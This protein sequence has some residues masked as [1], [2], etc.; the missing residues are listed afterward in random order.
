MDTK[1][2][3]AIVDDEENLRFLIRENLN[4]SGVCVAFS[5]ADVMAV[6]KTCQSE[7]PDIIVLDLLM[8]QRQGQEILASLKKDPATAAIPVILMSGLGG[9]L[10]EDFRKNV[11]N[12]AEAQASGFI[13]KPF[14]TDQLIQLIQ[15]VLGKK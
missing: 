6:E 5:I 8:P 14:H 15:S 2:K 11:V 7:Q 10:D 3:V 13:E 12:G 4:R 9:A 1:I